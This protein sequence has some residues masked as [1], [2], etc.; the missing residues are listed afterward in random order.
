MRIQDIVNGA[1]DQDDPANSWEREIERT[2]DAVLSEDS[3][4]K[5]KSIKIAHQRQMRKRMKVSSDETVEKGM[6]RYL[7]LIIDFSEAMNDRDLKPTRKL[8]TQKFVTSFIKEY[9]DQNP[10]S[11]LGLII[12]YNK[13]AQKI[14]ELSGNPLQQNR[15]LR[16]ATN[17][18]LH[19]GGEF[20]LQNALEYA[21]ASLKQ[22][23]P[24]GS[25]EILVIVGSLSTCDPGDIYETI[26]KIK[27]NKIRASVIGLAAQTYVCKHLTEATD[28]RH[29]V[30]M[31]QGH[32]QEVLMSHVKPHIIHSSQRVQR[33]WIRMGFPK[34]RTLNFP[35]ICQCHKEFKYTGY[36]CPKC[37]SKSCELPTD[38]EVCGRTLVSSSHLARCYHHLFPTTAYEEINPDLP[39]EKMDQKNG[40]RPEHN[41]STLKLT[42]RW[43]G[44]CFGCQDKL[45][46][47]EC[48]VV[49][50]PKCMQRFC[51]PCD[52]YIHESLHNCPGCLSTT[53]SGNNNKDVKR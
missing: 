42:E 44:H 13:I 29:D 6:V 19:H 1:D 33:R 43:T 35:T 9:F 28:G 34:K 18:H 50:C 4:G 20:S 3:K 53:T 12:G 45:D 46:T 31:S 11:Q 30:I 26:A 32:F 49:Q 48:V 24:Y 16:D 22:I 10:I 27:A 38:C 40:A 21:L 23:P 2:W 17:K 5:L 37:K 15:V 25:R 47:N 39:E 51:V 14:T 8:A 52:L 41:G 36:F 7:N